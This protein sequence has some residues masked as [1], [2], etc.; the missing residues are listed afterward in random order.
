MAY[1]TQAETT[2]RGISTPL[3][4][5]PAIRNPQIRRNEENIAYR[6]LPARPHT[7]S[8]HA[9]SHATFL[10]TKHEKTKNLFMFTY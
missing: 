6:K 3:A 7:I 9:L 5:A 10:A 1:C 4:K 8:R 2:I